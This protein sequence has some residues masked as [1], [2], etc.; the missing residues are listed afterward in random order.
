MKNWSLLKL[1]R[2]MAL[3][4]KLHTNV[5]LQSRATSLP[6]LCS[7]GTRY[8]KLR[9]AMTYKVVSLFPIAI[10]RDLVHSREL[11]EIFTIWARVQEQ[12]LRNANLHRI[13]HDIAR[14]I[15]LLVL[16]LGAP[17]FLLCTITYVCYINSKLFEG[18]QII[19]LFGKIV[20]YNGIIHV[21]LLCFTKTV[22]STS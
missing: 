2:L 12:H 20:A 3:W 1:N 15:W 19:A 4:T 21:M 22:Q 16:W 11:H 7:I 18:S 13:P 6:S 14:D 5:M 10:D 17:S 8:C 9:E